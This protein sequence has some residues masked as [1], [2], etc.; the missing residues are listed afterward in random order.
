MVGK[1]NGQTVMKRFTDEQ[2]AALEQLEARMEQTQHGYL[3][4]LR[5]EQKELVK[6]IYEA[7]EGTKKVNWG[8]G[9][10]WYD[11]VREMAQQYF[12]QKLEP[13]AEPAPKK[14]TAPKKK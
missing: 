5:S 11:I 2:M 7:A 9:R 8:C 14:K 12:A 6:G 10:C 4:S 1:T 13:K 3:T